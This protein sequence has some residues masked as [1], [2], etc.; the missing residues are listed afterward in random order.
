MK[1]KAVG[2]ALAILMLVAGAL[3]TFQPGAREDNE[4]LAALGPIL[5]GFGVAL[6]YV[7]LR[8]GR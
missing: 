7:I 1:A 2:L 5:A 3:W 6:V 4:T 8:R